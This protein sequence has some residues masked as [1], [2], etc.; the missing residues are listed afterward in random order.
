MIVLDTNV[1]SELMRPMPH[2]A[3]VRWVDEHGSELYLTTIS[4]AEILYG[5]ELLPKGERGTAILAAAS[6]IFQSYFSGRILSFGSEAATSYARI[7][8]DR[9]RSGRPISAFDAQ[10]A[11]IARANGAELATRNV[12]DFAGCGIDVIDPWRARK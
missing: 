6:E 1:V 2:E 12:A 11:A 10:I 5:V 8:A 7:A 3:V 4:Q 9:R